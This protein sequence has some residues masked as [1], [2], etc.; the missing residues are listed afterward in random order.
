M[1]RISPATKRSLV[2]IALLYSFPLILLPILLLAQHLAGAIVLAAMLIIG[3]AMLFCK[4]RT[5]RAS[6]LVPLAYIPFA[7]A[8]YARAKG[9]E[10]AFVVCVLLGLVLILATG[11]TN[12]FWSPYADDLAELHNGQNRP[13]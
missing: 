1:D 7:A 12:L 3:S 6:F 8:S 5:L 4:R 2:E 9:W 13:D 10:A 11:L